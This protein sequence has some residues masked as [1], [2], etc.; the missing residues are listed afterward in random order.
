MNAMDVE[1]DGLRLRPATTADW[2]LIRTWIGRPDIQRWWGN[3]A[4]AEAEVRLA[5]QTEQALSRIVL[6]ADA[7]IGYIQAIDA[8]HWGPSLPEGMPA[9]TWDVDLFIAETEHRGR[10]YG[11]RALNLIADEVFS[12]TFALALSV[13]VAVSNEAAVRAYERA[14]FRWARIWEDPIFGPSWMMLRDRPP[15]SGVR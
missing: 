14:G 8:S 3:P 10:G 7:P 6:L 15:L 9:G 12:T 11:E 13:F 1:A 5:L 4:A 2:P